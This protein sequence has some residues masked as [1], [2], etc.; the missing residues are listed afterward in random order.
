M[1][2]G[3]GFLIV[4]EGVDGVGKTT[5][6]RLLAEALRRRGYQ[7]TLTREPSDGPIGQKIRD[8][9]NGPG[10]HLTPEEELA[11]F[12][13]D[14]RDHVE[15]VIR[16]ALEAG[17]IVISDRY[18]FSSAAYQ[19]ALGI[20]PQRILAEHEQFAPPP[21]LAIFLHLAP[22]EALARQRGKTR[23]VSE[24][25]KYLAKVA[26]I[27]ETLQGPH[28]HHLKATGTPEEIHQKIMAVILKAL[29]NR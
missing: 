15:R 16:P 27:Y 20:D 5:Q 3:R 7:V 6:A 11:L 17:R 2:M 19:G 23:Q 14:R 28:L 12:V 18:Y 25:P 13:A 4:L 26:R 21:D 29:K 9:L 1:G 24:S 10:R 8:Y 22:L